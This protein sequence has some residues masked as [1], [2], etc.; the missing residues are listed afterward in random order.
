MEA[1]NGIQAIQ[2]FGIH[3]PRHR[4]IVSGRRPIRREKLLMELS[5]LTFWIVLD[6]LLGKMNADK[7]GQALRRA[8]IPNIDLMDIETA[9]YGL[10]KTMKA[11]QKHQVNCACFIASVSVFQE[12]K[13]RRRLHSALETARRLGAPLLMIIPSGFRE[14]KKYGSLSLAAKRERLVAGFR[15]AVQMSAGYGIRVCVEDTPSLW[16]P[17]SSAEDCEYLLERVPGLGL[18]FDTANMKPVGGDEI[19]FYERLKPF[20]CHVHLKDVVIGT[21]PHGEKMQDGTRMSV[22]VSGTGIVK[23]SELLE[24]MNRDGFLG[25]GAIEYA[26]PPGYPCSV[27]RHAETMKKYVEFL[28]NNALR[29]PE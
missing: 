2:S 25:T 17:L 21:D 20:I 3:L 22:T 14:E 23:L 11:L 15:L 7:I 1:Q 19:A 29:R 4:K 26:H 12:S 10:K 16:I 5:I 9:V 28:H 24:R 13:I 18:V 27:D 8:D 6:A